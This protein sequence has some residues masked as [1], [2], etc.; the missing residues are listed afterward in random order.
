VHVQQLPLSL[1]AKG[2]RHKWYLLY[3]YKAFT[4][5]RRLIVLKESVYSHSRHYTAVVPFSIAPPVAAVV[6]STQQFSLVSRPG[7]AAISAVRQ[8][9]AN[10]STRNN[11]YTLV[12]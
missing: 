9:L 8:A 1:T 5:A 3:A 7:T 6:E 10:Q 4:H 12:S 2:A 11:T